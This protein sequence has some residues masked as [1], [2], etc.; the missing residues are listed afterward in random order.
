MGACPL[1]PSSAPINVSMFEDQYIGVA[2][3]L[4]YENDVM[5]I[6]GLHEIISN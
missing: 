1:P 4:S 5:V 2:S 6:S 3:L